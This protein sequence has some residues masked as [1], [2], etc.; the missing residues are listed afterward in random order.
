MHRTLQKVFGLHLC[1]ALNTDGEVCVMLRV[2]DAPLAINRRSTLGVGVFY[3][4][5]PGLLTNANRSCNKNT[6]K[7]RSVQIK[8]VF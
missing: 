3:K 7:A 8:H 1:V 4:M 2:Q 5:V 6:P